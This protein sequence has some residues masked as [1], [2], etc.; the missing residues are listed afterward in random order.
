VIIWFV[1]SQIQSARMSYPEK[2]CKT[3]NSWNKNSW[4]VANNTNTETW[5]DLKSRDYNTLQNLV[6]QNDS[7][8]DIPL[9]KYANQ[10]FIDSASGDVQSGVAMAAMLIVECEKYNVFIDTKWL[11]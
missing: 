3:Y 8:L 4:A 5:L 9:S 11:K 6:T 10:W 2:F 1:G 7:A